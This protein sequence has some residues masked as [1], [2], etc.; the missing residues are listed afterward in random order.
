MWRDC[1]ERNIV[2]VIPCEGNCFEHGGSLGGCFP[3]NPCMPHGV[4][5][6]GSEK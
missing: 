5:E 4:V 3:H 6:G 2:L 1:N